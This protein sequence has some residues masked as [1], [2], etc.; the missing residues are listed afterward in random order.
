MEFLALARYHVSESEA[1]G[2]RGDVTDACKTKGS[3]SLA[4][5]CT[6]REAGEESYDLQNM[7]TCENVVVYQLPVVVG[8]DVATSLFLAR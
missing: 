3:Q 6:N 1:V 2:V 5:S 8:I 7:K 4:E